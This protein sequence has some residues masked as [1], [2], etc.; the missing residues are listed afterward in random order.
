VKAVGLTGALFA[1]ED[2]AR[3]D[4]EAIRGKAGRAAQ[5]A[6]AARAD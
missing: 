4:L 1:A 3:R 6:A 2:L 5:A